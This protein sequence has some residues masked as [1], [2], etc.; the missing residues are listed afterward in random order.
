MEK[1]YLINFCPTKKNQ[2]ISRNKTKIQKLSFSRPSSF[3]VVQEDS[4]LAARQH[5]K[6]SLA[7]H[8]QL[9][10]LIPLVIVTAHSCSSRP[11][12]C[13]WYTPQVARLLNS[14]GHN[15]RL[16]CD[17]GHRGGVL[18]CWNYGMTPQTWSYLHHFKAGQIFRQLW[19][20]GS[21]T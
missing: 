3:H 4:M 7:F 13:C 5:G 1:L 17:R 15:P 2:D 19:C 6:T 18:C 10:P 12:H 16:I 11:G 8:S 20:Y 9:S 14:E 21:Q